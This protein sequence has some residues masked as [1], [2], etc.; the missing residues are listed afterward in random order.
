[1]A[2]N[3]PAGP[4]CLVTGATNG[5]G[6][7]TARGLA[8]G[9]AHVIV[10]GRDAERTEATVR[11]LREE[12]GSDRLEGAVADLSIQAGV[13]RLAALVVERHR[14]LDVLINNAGAI[15][16][17]RE[18]TPDG[19]EMTWAV[20]HLAP[21]LLT[22]LLLGLLESSR[23]ARVVN[24]ASNAHENGRLD[25]DDLQ[26]ERRR[27]AIM[28]AY[29]QSKLADVLFTVELARRLEGTGVSANCLHPGFVGSNFGS[30]LGPA[31]GLF[32]RLLSPFVRS[33]EQGADTSI[34]LA[35]SPE[36]AGVSGGYF[37]DRKPSPPHR[38]AMD[39][40]ARQRLW[41]VSAEMTGLTPD[42]QGAGE[43]GR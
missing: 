32:W 21:F 8:R 22:N 43:E 13:R 39:L 2:T 5:I 10:G 12:T 35:T 15:R 1:M 29:S 3:D 25:F 30:Q 9:G 27:Y 11:S 28:G 24:V 26:F 41:D 6:L 33:S 4:V 23:P 18:L 42:R 34:Y 19:I 40:D 36:V 14:R 16:R 38:L 20:N 17:T 7:A 37:V 31:I